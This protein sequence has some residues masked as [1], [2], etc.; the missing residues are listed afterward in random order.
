MNDEMAGGLLLA[1][2][3]FAAVCL[4]AICVWGGLAQFFAGRPGG[5]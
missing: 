1:T 3:G 5:C 4:G 2:L